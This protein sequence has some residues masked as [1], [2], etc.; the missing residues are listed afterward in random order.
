M[1][2][3]LKPIE[4]RLLTHIE[5]LGSQPA[6]SFSKTEIYYL[7]KLSK[8]NL[9]IQERIH[10]KNHYRIFFSPTSHPPVC[11]DIPYGHSVPSYTIDPTYNSVYEQL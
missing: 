11:K 3:T 7:Q 6:N 4:Y 8:H 10:Y 9:L 2:I 1:E 5:K